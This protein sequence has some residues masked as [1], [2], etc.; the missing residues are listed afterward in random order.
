MPYRHACKAL[1]V[2]LT[3][4]C[5]SSNMHSDETDQ[6]AKK[7]A[8]ES[9]DPYQT[10]LLDIGRSYE[11]YRMLHELRY[12]QALCMPIVNSS[13]K[14]RS[15]IDRSFIPTELIRLSKAGNTPHGRKMYFLFN[16]EEPNSDKSHE[17][18][19]VG[20]VIVKEAWT[21][22]E[23]AKDLR[24]DPDRMTTRTR[25]HKTRK[26]VQTSEFKY[27]PYV[28]KDGKFYHARAKAELFIMFKM[29]PKTPG[30]DQGWVYATMTS[31]G[32]KVL[33]AGLLKSCMKCHCDA[34]N[35]RVF[36]VLLG[37]E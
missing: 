5:F 1:V 15:F 32:K 35:D 27:S 24:F 33:S 4:G 29:D 14:D 12:T 34:P 31:D 30:T 21:P 16:K 3:T 36:S 28:E 8:K 25:R 10:R 19:P 11:S 2:L 6:P 23:V 9:N 20:Q 7:P 18:H 37:P 17:M 22:E 13:Y 26:G